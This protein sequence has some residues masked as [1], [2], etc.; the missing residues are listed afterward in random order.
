M[1]VAVVIDGLETVANRFTAFADV[2]SE[3]TL[4]SLVLAAADI[5]IEEVTPNLPVASAEQH[6]PKRRRRGMLRAK[7]LGKMLM[8]RAVDAGPDSQT[9][10]VGFTR[11]G[12]Y[13]LWYELGTVHQPARPVVVPGFERKKSEIVALIGNFVTQTAVSW[14]EGADMGSFRRIKQ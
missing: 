12:F 10:G 3:E 4:A 14:Q 13:G 9:A 1:R 6:L 2:F 7:G 5:V 8:K 11:K